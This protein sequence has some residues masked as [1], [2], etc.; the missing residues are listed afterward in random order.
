MTVALYSLLAVLLASSALADDPVNNTFAYATFDSASIH[1]GIG[2]YVSFQQ[3]GDGKGSAVRIRAAVTGLS[4]LNQESF[5]WSINALPVPSSG[6]CEATGGH[7]NPA[8]IQEGK[9]ACT[10]DD[11]LFLTNC[12]AGN[13]GEKFGAMPRDGTKTGIDHTLKFDEILGLSV[14]ISAKDA[15][16]TVLACANIVLGSGPG[17]DNGNRGRVAGKTCSSSSIV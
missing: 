4:A 9:Q 10:E 16:K 11:A 14:A 2:G 1:N 8:N 15:P 17:L 7:Y 6:Q 3:S 12:A 5:L 13:L